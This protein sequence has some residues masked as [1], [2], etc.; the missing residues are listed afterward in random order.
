M[1]DADHQLAGGALRD[2]VHA[3][4]LVAPTLAMPQARGAQPAASLRRVRTRLLG[5]AVANRAAAAS[6]R[7]EAGRAD[8]MLTL[9]TDA[10]VR[11]AVLESAGSA[12][13]HV[14]RTR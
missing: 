11:G 4:Q 13:A 14:L 3:D 9:R 1:R 6:T 5:V 10:L 2:F 8:R 7:R 12:R